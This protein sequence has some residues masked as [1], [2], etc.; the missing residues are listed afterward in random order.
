MA[1]RACAYGKRCVNG[2][3]PQPLSNFHEHKPGSWR[4]MCRDCYNRSRRKQKLRFARSIPRCKRYLVTAAQNAT[5][6]HDLFWETL[7]KAAAHMGAELIVIPL[8]YQNPTS[9]FADKDQDWWVEEVEPYL[10]NGR[11]KLHP[12]LT[13][14]GNVK[15]QPTATHPL[16]GF[17]GMTGPESC[18]IGH[19]KLQL[20]T[21]AVPSSLYP[22]LMTTT[23][24]CTK[25]NYTDSRA[26]KT[27]EFH[28]HLGATLVELSSKYF[29]IRQINADKNDGSFIDW[30]T[31][32]TAT[33]PVPA[34]P[35]AAI[36]LGDVHVRVN[37]PDVDAA[38]FG[39]GG[40]ISTLNPVKIIAHDVSDGQSHNPHDAHDPFIQSALARSGKTD[41]RQELEEVVAWINARVPGREVFIVNSNHHDFLRRW[42]VKADWKTD[43]ENA[44]FYLET[45]LA[46]VKSARTLPNGP[47]YLDP[48][49]YW[50]Q[51]L[52]VA[53][54][55]HVLG[56]NEGLMI[57]GIECGMHGH[58]GPNGSKGTLKNLARLGTKV[59]SGHRHGPGIEEGHYGVGTSSYRRLS[60]MAGP[61]SHM[62]THCLIYANG[63]RTLVSV[64]D[65]EYRGG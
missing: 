47:T 33:G 15:V 40:I 6:V 8:R 55:V 21:V 4:S 9:V 3:K 62:N 45:A 50:L 35:P 65:G 31:L 51:R 53:A 13:V 14:L 59:I 26:G 18:I 27:S 63:K 22:K 17:E 49:P 52:G 7:T 28:H 44:E 11:R 34:P 48:F 57:S 56:K 16:T 30:D 25:A 23:G 37:D 1:K 29:H 58:W 60:Y 38:T 2:V 12:F 36:V 46:M 5:P 20:K 41:I 39:P 64:V 54:N 61:S 32:Y 19:T 10:Y 24:A 42:M 43:Q